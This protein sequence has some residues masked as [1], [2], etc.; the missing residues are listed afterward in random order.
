MKI[1]GCEWIDMSSAVGAQKPAAP[2][3]TLEREVRGAMSEASSPAQ[4]ELYLTEDGTLIRLENAD[5]CGPLGHA[6]LLE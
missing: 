3:R 2:P 4:I 5:L 1:E 6:N